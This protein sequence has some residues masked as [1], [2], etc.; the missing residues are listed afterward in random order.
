MLS[1]QHH[2]HA[3]GLVDVHKHT[4]LIKI[5]NY[6]L[7]K[8]RPI[9]YAETHAG[10]AFYDTS[11][12]EALKTGEAL[13][14][15]E[16]L[17]LNQSGSSDD[18]IE[19]IR[20]IRQERCNGSFYPGSPYIAKRL[21][22]TQDEMFLMELHP[23]EVTYLYGLRKMQGC[24]TH[25]HHR[26]GYEGVLAISPPQHRRGLVLIDPSYEVKSEYDAVADFALKLHNKWKEAV[27]M[28]WYPILSQGYHI[29]MLDKIYSSFNGEKSAVV[30][31]HI[32]EQHFQNPQRLM[33]SGLIVIGKYT[34]H[35]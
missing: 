17:L 2:Y 5:M 15:I 8:D 12:P 29:G 7:A 14:G 13:M 26:N 4:W 24:R 28:I 11:S 32:D 22:R 23:K 34:H 20:K 6:L 35:T 9:S 18:Y 30:P 1:Y 21:L 3:G 31:L 27:L 25:I 33:G 10:R 19:L 16:S